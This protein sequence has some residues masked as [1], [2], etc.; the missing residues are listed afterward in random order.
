M[1]LGMHSITPHK[2]IHMNLLTSGQDDLMLFL[3]KVVMIGLHQQRNCYETG[4]RKVG[5][6]L[7]SLQNIHALSPV[8]WTQKSD[9]RK[10]DF[11]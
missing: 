5:K 6:V 1:Y 9:L 2:Q 10:A 3:K 11:N 8:F 7:V 4:G